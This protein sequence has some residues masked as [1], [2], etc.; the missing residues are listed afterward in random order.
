MKRSSLAALTAIVSAGAVF[1]S[2][3]GGASDPP[4]NEGDTCVPGEAMTID[5]LVATSGPLASIGEAM[6]A[7]MNAAVTT[8]NDSGG[9]LGSP[10]SLNLINNAGAPDQTAAILQELIASGRPHA[11]IPGSSSE[12]AAG[13]PILANAGVFTAHH[14][15]GTEFNDPEKYPYAFGSAHSTDH[16][17]GPLAAELAAQG[18]KKIGYL[19]QD[20]AGGEA[21]QETAEKYF[22]QYGLE[23]DF[24]GVANEAID[25]TPQLERVLAGDPDALVFSAFGPLAGVLAQAREKLEVDLPTYGTQTYTANPLGSLAPDHVYDDLILQSVA[26]SVKG[27][28]A[29]ESEAFKTFFAALKE[30]TNGEIPFGINAYLVTYNDV[31]LA[32][33]AANLAGCI[34]PAKM[35]EAIE[36]AESSDLPL[37]VA[38]VDFSADD[39]YANF[40]EEWFIFHSYGPLEDGLI[41]PNN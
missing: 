5:A 7:G 3:C 23:G 19:R 36:N 12:M 37:Y 41:V 11:V 22:N 4:S 20:D 26:T 38:P 1:L 27:T 25:A 28:E 34:D 40:S 9:V 17:L 16:Y 35:A 15:P 33:S 6:T 24:V 2:A 31:I 10:L 21:N 29:A 13:I 39:H 30:E 8:I 32:A 14:F 18:Y